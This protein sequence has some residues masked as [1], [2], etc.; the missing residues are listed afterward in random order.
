[1]KVPYATHESVISRSNVRLSV[2]KLIEAESHEA[3]DTYWNKFISS[4]NVDHPI[5]VAYFKKM[6]LDRKY[7][8]SK[9]WRQVSCYINNS[10]SNESFDDIS[11]PVI[12]EGSNDLREVLLLQEQIQLGNFIRDLVISL[13]SDKRFQQIKQL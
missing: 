12:E 10:I 9:A 1:M 5:F 11:N 13:R 7:L 4:F 8:W 6:W 3:F 2:S